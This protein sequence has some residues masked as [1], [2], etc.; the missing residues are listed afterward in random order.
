M[1][2]LTRAWPAVLAWLVVASACGQGSP[3]SPSRPV[4]MVCE[5]PPHGAM[6]AT[7]DG[8]PW[9]PSSTTATW[10]GG[11]GVGFI[12][13]EGSD[14]THAL[15]IELHRFKGPGTYE[16]AGGDVS[17]HLGC[18][19]RPCGAWHAGSGSVTVASYTAPTQGFETSGAIEGTFSFTLA[20]AGQQ[21]D[22]RVITNGRFGSR[23]GAT[24]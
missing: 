16:V 12:I 10:L 24:Y 11:V 21:P 18:D 5:L 13:L 8:T 23:F 22:T 14:C 7:I 4:V 9:I 19:G 6:T 1:R 3:T 20:P 2:P 17:V 15:R